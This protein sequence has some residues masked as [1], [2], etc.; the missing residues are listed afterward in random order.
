L[1]DV[2]RIAEVLE[3]DLTTPGGVLYQRRG[4]LV[5]RRYIVYTSFFSFFLYPLEGLIWYDPALG[6]PELH[7][8]NG[9]VIYGSR[10]VPFRRIMKHVPACVNSVPP[11]KIPLTKK[12][13]LDKVSLLIVLAFIAV[14]L[15]FN[16]TLH[17]QTKYFMIAIFSFAFLLVLI[18]VIKS[19]HETAKNMRL[20]SEIKDMDER[21]R[22][23]EEMH[24]KGIFQK[25][26]PEYQNKLSTIYYEKGDYDKALG[27]VRDAINLRANTTVIIGPDATDVYRLNEATYLTAMKQDD[28]AEQL[29]DALEKGRSMKNPLFRHA[30]YANRA[31]ISIHRGDSLAAR[32]FLN[33]AKLC[34]P[35][36]TKQAQENT[37]WHM[38]LLEAECD[39]LEHDGQSAISKLKDIIANCT[40]TPSIRHAEELLTF[41]LGMV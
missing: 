5:T 12:T 40:F 16:A 21:I 20:L 6:I 37:L 24:A 30:I 15:I 3:E 32:E 17:V 33:Q 22:K 36:G 7:Y 23:L 11:G 25:A 26:M 10:F 29:L 8:E 9:R 4:T 1:G 31:Q 28:E 19:V 18:I 41:V 13:S 27:L 34:L 35:S 38:L 14:A 2:H 39:L